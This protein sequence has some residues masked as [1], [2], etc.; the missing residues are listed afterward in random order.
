MS[1][2]NGG[3]I[4]PANTPVGGLFKGVAGGVWRM[5]DVL[6]FV[7]NSQWPTGPK[8][9][10]NSCRFDDGSTDYLSGPNT[11]AGSTKTKFTFS[12][13][14]KRANLTSVDDTVLGKWSSG[15]DRGHINFSDTPDDSIQLFEKASGSTTVHLLT[16]R[17]FRDVS[18]WYNIV[19]IGDT[20]ESTSSDRLKLFVNGVQETSF[21]TATYPSE[22]YEWQ[23]QAIAKNF[24]IGAFAAENAGG[25]PSSFYLAEVVYLDGVVGSVSDF[26]ETDSTTGIWKPKKIGGFSSAGDNS[27]YLDFKD[28]SNLGNDAS[29]LNNDFTVNNLTSIDQTTDTCVENF[30]TLNSLGVTAQTPT[31]SEGNTKFTI[32]ST[33]T[34]NLA[35]STFAV[36]SGKWYSEF[37]YTA[38]DYFR[39][40]ILV[41]SKLNEFPSG[42]IYPGRSAKGWD[43]YS[44]NGTYANNGSSTS[45]GNSYSTG[46]IIG[47]AVD[48]ENNYLYFS[49]NGTFQNSGD[50]T[51]GSTGT[52]GINISSISGEFIYI[53][54]A[55]YDVSSGGN[56][57][58]NFGNPSFSISSGN[59]DANGF[60]NFEYSVPSGYY[61]LN[62]SNLN[63]YG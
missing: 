45:Y 52:G 14:I 20:T 62:T 42:S 28:S 5:N 12:A 49:K 47:V 59:A 21:G 36:S 13:W 33:N 40:G 18:A 60:G 10:E 27:F 4:G 17:L 34:F 7:S 50:P 54:G 44:D 8:D 15:N 58:V 41:T 57:Q 29:G 63:T 53:C 55:I 16:N 48:L 9:I 31:F 25:S 2:K 3:I 37:K 1:R 56:C 46:D 23:L 43:Y 38:G 6:D 61:A 26:G 24:G 32:S 35:S 22:N 39:T 19:Y 11:T 51:S 30:A